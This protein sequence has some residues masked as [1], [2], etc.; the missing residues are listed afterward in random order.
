MAKIILP[1]DHPKIHR[2]AAPIMEIS[3]TM[4]RNG[5]KEGKNIRPLL[6]VEV[7]KEID[8]MGFYK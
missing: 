3:S 6:P 5:I 7:W 4:I 2:V 1:K 8:T